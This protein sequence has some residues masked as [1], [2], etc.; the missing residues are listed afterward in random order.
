MLKKSLF[1]VALVAMLAVMAQAG[2]IKT[3]QWPTGGYV[4]MKITEI[5]VTMDVGYW[6][7]IVDQDK[8]KIKLNQDSIH[9]YQGCTAMKVQCNFNVILSCSITKNGSVPGD[10]ACSISAPAVNSPGATVDV[11]ATLKKADLSAT[12]GG[13]NN[14]QVATVIINVV[15]AS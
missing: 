10:Y 8:L 14:I 6:V 13:T 7:K 1:V 5:P 11:C 9:E 15:P 3:H 2:E 4:P 12:P